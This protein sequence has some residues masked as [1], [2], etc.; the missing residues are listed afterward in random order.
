MTLAKRMK[1]F[2]CLF[3]SLQLSNIAPVAASE[4]IATDKAVA[5]AEKLSSANARANDEKTV[6]QFLNRS[7]IKESLIKRGLSSEEATLRLANLSDTEMK[8]LAEN[9]EQEKAGGILVEI[10]IV[11]LIIFLIKRM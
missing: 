8:F 7:Q 6:Q 1:T 11:V 4:L 3:L 9:I 5:A 10:L 2:I